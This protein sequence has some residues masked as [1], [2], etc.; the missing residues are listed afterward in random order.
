[1]NYF[2]LLQR[3]PGYA[4]LWAA[5]AVSLVGDWFNTI[6]LASLVAKYS[7]SS[8][9]AISLLLLARFLPPL[10]VSPI[11][12]VLLDRFDRRRLLIIS[13]I[14]RIFIVLGFLLV[15]SAE[16]LWLVYALTV[17]QFCFSSVF[18]PGR[19]ALLPSLVQRD[20]LVEANILGS[21][22]W[23]VMLAI[24]GILG[25]VISGLL[26]TSA[27]LLF[28]A[29]TFAISAALIVS[30]R[31]P[32]TSDSSAGK[33]QSA[34]IKDYIDGL[35][36]V[37]RHPA[38]LATLLVKA[39]GSVGNLDGILIIY[40]TVLFV[41]GQDGNGS[42][43]ILWCAFGI[44]AII[45][46]LLLNRW[47]DSTVRR[48]R[49]LILAAYALIAVGWFLMAGAPTLAFASFAI[50]VKA[51]GS[52]VYWTYSSAILQRTVPDNYLGRVFSLDMA[53][54]QLAAVISI[55]I[56][57]IALESWGNDQVRAVTIFT[58]IASLIPLVLW[59]FALRWLEKQPEV[60]LE[61]AV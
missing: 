6:V 20:D 16:Q 4:R 44:G 29:S 51:M 35:H 28:D 31:M 21:V 27:A 33:E 23:S 40:A 17:A 37:R 56:T 25:G 1:M 55:I 47:N 10:L 45:G 3:N 41:V 49:R 22:T 39:G 14:A 60:Q 11:A 43:G 58:G 30:I 7:E 38:T 9:L 26:G 2:R 34:S 42:L 53:G 36:Y 24:G 8:G 52:S 5:Q 50:M 54:F 46:P 12:G 13:D 19:S 18:E 32:L 48:L 57:G 15:Q 61:P 59:A